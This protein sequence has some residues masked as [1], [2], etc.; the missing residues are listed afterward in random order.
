MRRWNF[1]GR[2]L[3]TRGASR[4]RN[5]RTSLVIQFI[6]VS[7]WRLIDN[8]GIR[9][10]NDFILLDRL[11]LLLGT[12]TRFHSIS[13]E[14]VQFVSLILLAATFAFLIMLLI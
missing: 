9:D 4:L 5:S 1:E 6:N 11:R 10:Q 14:P 2:D 8:G 3:G 7:W 13:P 12:T